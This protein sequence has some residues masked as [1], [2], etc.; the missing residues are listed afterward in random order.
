MR[1]YKAVMTPPF[2]ASNWHG[3]YYHEGQWRE[4]RDD[5]GEPIV[6]ASAKVA[7]DQAKDFQ[8]TLKQAPG[9]KQ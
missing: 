2:E 8:Q 6:F 3:L 7:K 5:R 1:P 4:V 9:V